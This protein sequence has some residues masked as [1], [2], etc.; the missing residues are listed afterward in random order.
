VGLLDGLAASI[1]AGFKGKLI[2]GQLRRLVAAESSGLDEFGDPLA[3]VPV[4]YDLEGFTDAYS[5]FFR[6]TS[7]IPDTDLK[8]NIFGASCAVSPLKD[9][10]VVFTFAGETTWYQLR[11]VATD[12]ARVLW[13]CQSY[14]IRPPDGS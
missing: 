7:G 5:D 12:P 10:Q 1:Y 14:V 6:A 4:L 13:V 9:D 8:V 11:K 2:K 3:P